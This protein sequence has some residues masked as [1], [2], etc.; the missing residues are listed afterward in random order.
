MKYHRDTGLGIKEIS[1]PPS[2]FSAKAVEQETFSSPSTSSAEVVE[3]A[4][5]FLPPKCRPPKWLKSFV[6][7]H[8]DCHI[9]SSSKTCSYCSGKGHNI[10]GYLKHKSDLANK[11]NH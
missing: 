8:N 9:S 7:E 11:E 1:L 5:K 10:R 6:K 4:S 2:M 3:L